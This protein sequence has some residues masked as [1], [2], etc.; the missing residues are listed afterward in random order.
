MTPEILLPIIFHRDPPVF[1]ADIGVHL[2]V[3]WK[4]DSG[5]E[6][7]TNVKLLQKV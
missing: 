6:N 5:V 4:G 2:M 7:I 1:D 3:T